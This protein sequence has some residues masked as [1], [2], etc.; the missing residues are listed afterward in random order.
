MARALY[1]CATRNRFAR[2][3]LRRALAAMGSRAWEE[4]YLERFVIGDA[5][6]AYGVTA[7]EKRLWLDAFRRNTTDIESGTPLLVHVALTEALLRIGPELEGDVVECGVWKGSSAATLSLVCRRTGR[8]LKVCDSFQGLPDDGMQ[9]H[10]GLHTRVF[11][12]YKEGMFTGAL[13]EVRENI[14]RY[15]ALEVCDFVPGFFADSLHTLRGPIVF[16]FLDVDLAASTRDCLRGIWPLLVEN[17]LLYCDDAGDLDVVKVYFDDVW[18]R[19]NL[20]CAAPG[21]VGSGCGLPLRPGFSSLGYT[22]K[23]TAFRSEEWRRAPFLH[24]PSSPP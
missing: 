22:R 7:R 6:M 16:A 21:L 20:G 17:G 11:G 9:L 1:H 3:V 14:G 12:Y 15:G 8:R 24:Y 18:W 19:Q 4:A 5:G 2:A 10:T 13:D 23:V